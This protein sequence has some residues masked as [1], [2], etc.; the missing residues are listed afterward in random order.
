MTID[1][2]IAKY[3][4]KF[5]QSQKPS[6]LHKIAHHLMGGSGGP[7]KPGRTNNQSGGDGTT[8]RNIKRQDLDSLLDYLKSVT[9][10]SKHKTKRKYFVILYGPPA[11]GKT[12]ARKIACDLI[13]EKYDEFH[14][15]ELYETFIDTGVDEITYR[16]ISTKND[17]GETANTAATA[18]SISDRAGKLEERTV[19]DALKDNAREII[20]DGDDVQ[21]ERIAREKI[22]ELV[23]TSFEI[24]RH[25]RADNISELLYYLSVFLGMNIFF[26][27]ASGSVD[28]IDG[29]LK[30]LGYYDYI[31]IVVYPFIRD[32]NILYDRS[33]KRG[34]KEGRFLKCGSD[35]GISAHMTNSLEG[36]DTLKEIIRT[37]D[38]YII[39]MYDAEFDSQE[40]ERL[41]DYYFDSM[42]DH[43][44]ET[45]YAKIESVDILKHRIIEHSVHQDFKNKTKLNTECRIE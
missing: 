15:K 31:P 16:V 38:E 27:T 43:I 39:C 7:G 24:Y 30:N 22:D 13:Y 12:V 23:R 8:S 3:A 28:Y 32:V 20:G 9:T 4:Y 35:Y 45:E 42:A 10:G 18:A 44:L 6:Y 36:Y 21:R 33:I 34:L 25:D 26:E 14:P 5:G 41:N 19:E 2:K 37:K 11:S 17:V 29:I 1:Y 40:Y